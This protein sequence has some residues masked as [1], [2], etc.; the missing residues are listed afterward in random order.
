MCFVFIWEQTATCATCI[1]N[2]LVFITEMKSVHCAVRTGSLNKQSV[3][4]IKGLIVLE[5]MCSS[6]HFLISLGVHF[7]PFFFRDSSSRKTFSCCSFVYDLILLLSFCEFIAHIFYLS[8]C[9]SAG[10]FGCGSPTLS[11][12]CIKECICRKKT[13]ISVTCGPSF[14][15]WLWL[16]RV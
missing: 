11:F 14:S 2:W 9:C 10:L 8:S 1:I 3:L 15:C 6:L 5:L 7:F 12:F 13:C 4:R 16:L